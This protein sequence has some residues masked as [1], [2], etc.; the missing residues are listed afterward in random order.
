[1]LFTFEFSVQEV[2]LNPIKQSELAARLGIGRSAISNALNRGKLDALPTGEI[3]LDGEASRAYLARF[4]RHRGKQRT[5][6]SS[7]A[8]AAAMLARAR[9]LYER[10]VLR[11]KRRKR[12]V[13]PT[14]MINYSIDN[15]LT[16]LR[17][18][19]AALPE[20]IGLDAV[21]LERELEIGI[22]Q[23]LEAAKKKSIQTEM[24]AHGE[25]GEAA[26]EYPDVLPDQASLD[27]MPGRL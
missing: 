4:S 8:R 2:V 23:A 6:P 26:V 1:M 3:D 9:S 24:P 20:R 15:L 21:N 22:I 11:F 7:P 13:I 14:E 19:V 12:E 17:G 18:E 10:N 5:E 25:A 16:T 27:E